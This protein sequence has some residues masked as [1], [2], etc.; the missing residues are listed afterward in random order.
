MRM[1]DCISP[2]E[3]RLICQ[4]LKY[5]SNPQMRTYSHHKRKSSVLDMMYGISQ[6][7]E[8]APLLQNSEIKHLDD[9]FNYDGMTCLAYYTP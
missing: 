3:G 4:H 2:W 7:F 8:N 6:T 5:Y 9:K 1:V